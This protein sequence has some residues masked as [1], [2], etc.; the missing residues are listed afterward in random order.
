MRQLLSSVVVLITIMAITA[1]KEEKKEFLSG[2]IDPEIFPTM[3]TRDVETLIS[4]SGITRYRIISP[5]WLVFDESKVPHCR[6]P[7]G[8]NL[9][10]FD[11]L[12]SRD[13]T[14]RCDSATYFKLEQLWRLD[15]N[16]RIANVA[17]EKFLTNQLFWDQQ[18][19]KIYS[20]SFIHIEKSDRVIEG[21]G[22]VSDE[23]MTNYTV[24]NVS[25][26][27]PVGEEGPMG[28]GTQPSED[29]AAGNDT[30][31]A[32]RTPPQRTSEKPRPA[33]SGSNQNVNQLMPVPGRQAGG[34]LQPKRPVTS[35][36]R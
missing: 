14:V 5:L 4:D 28:A 11:D 19:H 20:D 25:G 31:A 13:G 15:G 27:F 1:C 12:M 21:Y 23:Q 34:T 16:V 9:E 17:K 7:A 33:S 29:T 2:R 30:V 22:F 36:G 24:N 3:M 32:V 10:L 26:I 6:F 8:L 35:L 18:N